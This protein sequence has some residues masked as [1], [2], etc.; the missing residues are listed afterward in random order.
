M[1]VVYAIYKQ[2]INPTGFNNMVTE[3]GNDVNPARRL[4]L[5]VPNGM[6]PLGTVTEA[7][8]RAGP[9]NNEVRGL[10]NVVLGNFGTPQ[11]NDNLF[12]LIPRPGSSVRPEP[13]GG[14]KSRRPK[15]RVR[16]SKKK[17]HRSKKYRARK[18]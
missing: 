14:R 7:A 18:R 12:I 11:I 10:N 17:V 3:D 1:A 2:I 16:R 4:Y 5:R 9:G 13:I 15:K 8:A 6:I